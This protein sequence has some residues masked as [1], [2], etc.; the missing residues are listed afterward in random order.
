MVFWFWHWTISCK[1]RG[2]CNKSCVFNIC[3]KGKYACY[4]LLNAFIIFSAKVR[5]HMF[6][7]CFLHVPV[8][9][10]YVYDIFLGVSDNLIFAR[11]CSM[12]PVPDTGLSYL[13]LYFA[14]PVHNQMS[15]C[16]NQTRINQ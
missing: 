8:C 6:L 4:D 7:I 13:G 2:P 3:V 15:P 10:I 12:C 16:I 14:Q 9:C 5:S 1:N 11:M